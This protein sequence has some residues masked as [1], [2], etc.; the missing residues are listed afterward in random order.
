MTLL[1]KRINFVLSV[2][3]LT[4][5][6]LLADSGFYFGPAV[7]VTGKFKRAFG[8]AVDH[9]HELLLVADTGNNQ[10]KWAP[11]S[12]LKDGDVSFQKAGGPYTLKGPQAV[13]ADVSH[14]YVLS[15]RTGKVHVFGWNMESADGGY[16]PS[17]ILCA[18]NAA[19]VDD[20]PMLWPRDLVVGPDNKI[21][22]L[23]SGNKRILVADSASDSTWAVWDGDA[24]WDNPYGMDMDEEGIMYVADTGNHRIVKIDNGAKTFIGQWGTGLGEFRYPRDVAVDAQGRL[25]VA[26]TFNH[27]VV[28]LDADGSF[29][30]NLGKAPGVGTLNKIAV[31]E[32]GRIY[33]T[34]SD[35][36][37]IISYLKIRSSRKFDLYMRDHIGDAGKSFMDDD[38]VLSS[39]DILIRHEADV[40]VQEAA[41]KGLES[42]TFQLPR[43]GYK[44]YVYVALRNKGTQPALDNFVRLYW[45]D[46]KGSGLFPSK[47]KNTGFYKKYNSDED[48]VPANMLSVP[49]L[50]GDSVQVAGPL[51]WRPPDPYT[52]QDGFGGLMLSARAWHADDPPPNNASDDHSQISNNVTARP[53]TVIPDPH[54][55][56]DQNTLVVAV[57]YPDLDESVVLEDLIPILTQCGQWVKEASWHQTTLNAF[58]RGPIQLKE[59]SAYYLKPTNNLLKEMTQDVLEKL[60]KDEP[61][62]LD[63]SEDAPAVHRV[64][65]VTNDMNAT[66]DWSTTG[67]RLY[68]I[69]NKKYSLSVSVQG[70]NN[71]WQEFAHGVGHQMGLKDLYAYDNVVF[72]KPFADGWDNMAK[73]FDGASPLVW[74]KEQAYW[75][76]SS[77]R[78][79]VFVPRPVPGATWNNNGQAIPLYAQHSSK[80]GQNVAIAFGVTNGITTLAEETAFYYVEYR[81]ED[82][83]APQTGV[84]VYYVNNETP[85]G[86]GPVIL[87]D[88]VPGGDL[89]DAVVPAGKS[90]SPGGTGIKITVKKGTNGAAANIKV[91]YA[92]PA[93]DYDVYIRKGNPTHISP[94]I[95]VDSPLNDF[96][97]PPKD[98]GEEA[99]AGD[100]N[101][102]YAQVH[103]SGP[104]HAHDVEVEYSFSDPYSAIDG[105][106]VYMSTFITL[107]KANKKTQAHV[108]WEPS[109]EIEDS[110]A[111]AKVKLKN[112][113]NDNKKSNNEAQ[114]N[115]KVDRSVHSSPYTPVKYFFQFTNVKKKPQLVY[116]EAEGVPEEWA[117]SLSPLKKLVQP[118]ET[119][120][121][122]L[123]LQPPSDAP[124]CTSHRVD[125]MAWGPQGDTL[126]PLGGVSV[127]VDLQG[128]TK[129][130][131]DVVVENCT[132]KP[133]HKTSN[134]K[135]CKQIQVSGCTQPKQVFQDVYVKYTG[136]DGK[137]IYH[138]VQTDANG[139]YEDMLVVHEG[140]NWQVTAHTPGSDCYEPA[141]AEAV[142]EVPLAVVDH[143]ESELPDGYKPLCVTGFSQ[144]IVGRLLKSRKEKASSHACKTKSYEQ[145]MEM[146]LVPNP[147]TPQ[148]N[149]HMGGGKIKIMNLRH[150][151]QPYKKTQSGLH[152]GRFHWWLTYDGKTIEVM[153]RVKGLTHVGT[154]HKPAVSPPNEKLLVPG[155]WEL[156]L[157]GT[158]INGKQK[159]ERVRASVALRF[160]QGVLTFPS[161]ATDNLP[162]FKGTVEG[163]MEKD[164]TLT[165][166]QKEKRVQ[167]V[168][169]MMKAPFLGPC[170]DGLPC[171]ERV[172]LAGR[173][174]KVMDQRGSNHCGSSCYTK[175]TWSRL[176]VKMKSG[177]PALAKGIL[178]V[179]HL[180]QVTDKH[181]KGRGLQSGLFEYR[182]KKGNWVKGEML[183]V[184][185]SGTHRAP[186]F[187]D[188][189]PADAKDHTEGTLR[190]TVVKGPSK[191]CQVEA[192]Y[193]MQVAKQTDFRRSHVWMNV[194][195]WK[196]TGCV[197]TP[198]L[199]T[200]KTLPSSAKYKIT[201]NN[202]RLEQYLRPLIKLPR[203]AVQN[204]LKAKSIRRLSK[205]D[206]LK[207]R[208]ADK[209]FQEWDKNNDKHLT[210]S[211]FRA[212]YSPRVYSLS[213]KNARHPVVKKMRAR[214]AQRKEATQKG[215]P[216]EF[217]PL[218]L[219]KDGRLSREEQKQA[220]Q[221]LSAYEFRKIDKNKNKKID[222]SEYAL[223]YM[224]NKHF[225][226]LDRIN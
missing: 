98:N 112:L 51:I 204:Y 130:N 167:K 208:W 138:T 106:K 78:K 99:M 188:M 6:G 44:N 159:G 142:T 45:Y 94:D 153:G 147:K 39:P 221:R 154:H 162:D 202:K 86:H 33:V 110:H 10:L 95:W 29:K 132:Q 76:S 13:A 209:R 88:Y 122:L 22:M 25:Y 203:K 74:S 145:T 89:T 56:G 184:V 139:C 75:A 135:P 18:D 20:L 199:T 136:P 53:V 101:R 176:R 63:G 179:P 102:V 2:L 58:Y 108:L 195:G 175:K 121:G 16:I 165:K 187:A 152:Q 177:T 128:K 118:Q 60:L 38:F 54:P 82:D 37:H 210:L 28:V 19:K 141:T 26:D 49:Y 157:H 116:F 215:L 111:C 161:F 65:L 173:G 24:S 47:W 1:K 107:L 200:N 223:W 52:T 171:L 105:F 71:T 169:K 62:L 220:P 68:K 126:A 73:P 42:Y 113:F 197:D 186:P 207:L 120:T 131:A 151:L 15:P 90:V 133:G 85:Q 91:K 70:A 109:S 191:G 119:M 50:S 174:R 156:A 115:L 137:P 213:G 196:I 14:A 222:F 182:D 96:T 31:D 43:Y 226:T 140:E 150:L 178:T 100:K 3:L 57:H 77:D 172:A 46:A 160:P 123:T 127:Q 48:S 92:P 198:V 66:K 218:D 166:L 117:S 149:N 5:P 104:A 97:H 205:K 134:A 170:E 79:I 103:N 194:D 180:L 217:A 125:V 11:L 83:G 189:E 81:H 211:E 124:D 23:D 87:H 61:T 17:G 158:V 34:D 181:E 7:H 8:V 69:K 164:C 93:E 148:Y 12:Q 67:P 190:G 155:Y 114:Q 219:N 40:D 144:N 80:S 32:F 225:G 36:S 143:P 64:I 192:R 212:H 146:T 168:K 163:V 206:E 216:R 214:A 30:M 59:T 183:G 224:E 41:E 201:T 4:T 84:I 27:R 129:L 72:P 55:S 35:R 185:R 9:Q 193:V 21:Y